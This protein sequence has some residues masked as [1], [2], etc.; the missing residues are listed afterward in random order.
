MLTR[1]SSTTGTNTMGSFTFSPDN[2]LAQFLS[3]N[4]VRAATLDDWIERVCGDI[5]EQDDQESCRRR[6]DYAGFY[7]EGIGATD[8]TA[9]YVEKE[10]SYE[11]QEGSK[12]S[13]WLYRIVNS[14]S[15]QR[16][17]SECD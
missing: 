15:R 8:K 17:S 2:M 14:W 7:I 3:H 10:I 9:C 4:A 5:E 11:I 6:N 13:N 16:W 1:T 12:Q